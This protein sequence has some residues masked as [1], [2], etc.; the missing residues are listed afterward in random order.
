MQIRLRETL[1]HSI[2]LHLQILYTLHLLDIILHGRIQLV[3]MLRSSL[4]VADSE[5]IES[6]Q[7]LNV[8]EQATTFLSL[9]CSTGEQSN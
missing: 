7:Q 3:H 4:V 9:D 5:E 6:M 8:V 1:A 2:Q